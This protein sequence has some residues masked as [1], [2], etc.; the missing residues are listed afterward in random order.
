MPTFEQRMLR[1]CGTALPC[2]AGSAEQS[3]AESQ[4][5]SLPVVK[6]RSAS[7]GAVLPFGGGRRGCETALTYTASLAGQ[8]AADSQDASLPVVKIRSASGGAAPPLTEVWDVPTLEQRMLRGCG[9][10]LPCPAGSAGQSAAELQNI[11]LPVV[12]IRS[13]SG[14]AALPYGAKN[15]RAEKPGKA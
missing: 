7:G 13:A 12:K 4:D 3:A 2:P 9:T 8:S 10:A 5:A 11:S 14:D 1:G 6:I 15:T